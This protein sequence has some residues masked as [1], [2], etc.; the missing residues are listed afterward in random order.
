M[1]LDSRNNLFEFTFPRK[2]IPQDIINKY[3]PYLN[4]IPGSLLEEPIDF[5]NYSIQSINM[6]GMNF[7]PVTQSDNDGTTRYHRGYVPIQNTIERQFTVT[8]QLLDGFIN[9]WILMDTFLYYYA[10]QT[11]DKYIADIPLNIIDAEGLRV[12]SILFEKPIMN[13]LSELDLNFSTNIAEFNRFTAT[14]YYNKLN[15]KIEL[16]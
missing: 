12:A 11:K 13:S 7:D 1:I 9:Y 2:F 8:F 4:K 16:D 6:P 5:L 15:I 3:K 10:K 14:F